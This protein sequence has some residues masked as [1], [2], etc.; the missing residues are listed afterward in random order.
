MPG[1]KAAAEEY[2]GLILGGK[3]VV[4]PAVLTLTC[5]DDRGSAGSAVQGSEV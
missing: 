3:S 5:A 4:L 2:L 1:G